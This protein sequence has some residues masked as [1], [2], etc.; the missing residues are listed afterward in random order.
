MEPKVEGCDFGH[1]NAD[2]ILTDE[3]PAPAANQKDVLR[4]KDR[5]QKPEA[6]ANSHNPSTNQQHSHTDSF[7][8]SIHTSLELANMLGTQVCII[9]Y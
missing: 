3:K 9:V 6:R 7:L 8:C 1:G 2:E 4:A 5:S